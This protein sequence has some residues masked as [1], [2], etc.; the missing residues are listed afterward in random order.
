MSKADLSSSVL[1]LTA[2][3]STNLN[4]FAQEVGSTSRGYAENRFGNAPF[5]QVHAN[6]AA[7]LQGELQ[8]VRHLA[9]AYQQMPLAPSHLDGAGVSKRVGQLCFGDPE[10]DAKSGVVEGEQISADW[11]GSGCSKENMDHLSNGDILPLGQPFDQISL[12]WSAALHTCLAYACLLPLADWTPNFNID[13]TKLPYY[14]PGWASNGVAMSTVASQ[15]GLVGAGP[16]NQLVTAGLEA[17][18]Q[19]LDSRPASL[20][21]RVVATAPNKPILDGCGILTSGTRHHFPQQ[22]PIEI[23]WLKQLSIETSFSFLILSY[24]AIIMY[25]R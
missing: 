12:L 6:E 25:I 23:L 10:P 14:L 11:L 20:D 17:L 13:S 19:L 7:R 15:S 9:L 2:S 5:P 18:H 3:P 1:P 22:E 24:G 16:T 21:R 4:S 8:A